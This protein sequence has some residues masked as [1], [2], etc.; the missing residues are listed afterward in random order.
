MI[1]GYFLS[2]CR[3]FFYFLDSFLRCTKYFILL[4]FNLF[5]PFVVISKTSLNPRWWKF[6]YF[7]S[8]NL[9]F[10]FYIG[11]YGPFWVNFCIRYHVYDMVLFSPFISF[12]YVCW[13][14]SAP[15]ITKSMLSPLKC[16]CI[17]LKISWSFLAS[18]VPLIYVCILL[19]VPHSL[20]YS[21]FMVN[22][23]LIHI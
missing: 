15:F 2:F 6:L 9:F 7:S 17:L 8:R 5:F 12:A 1:C 4:K 23:K 18:S 13:V 21:S 11:V 10:L 16:F 22:Y 14:A 3:L 20:D 19:P